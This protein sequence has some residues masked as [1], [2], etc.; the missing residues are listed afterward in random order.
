MVN[1]CYS[2]VIFGGSVYAANLPQEE[3]ALIY[4]PVPAGA[5]NSWQPAGVEVYARL[6]GRTTSYL[7]AGATTQ[8]QAALAQSDI[9]YQQLDDTV[10][11]RTYYLAAPRNNQSLDAK[12]YGRILHDDGYQILLRTTPQQAAQLAETGAEIAKLN[13]TLLQAPTAVE[14][15]PS[16]IDADPIV[17][18][19]ID[20]VSE[21]AVYQYDGSLSGEWPIIISGQEYTLQ[22]RHTYSGVPIQKATEYVGQHLA[23]L[24][25]NV[26]YH[27]WNGSTYPNV[28]AELPGQTNPEQIFIICAHLDDMPSGST[29]PGADDNASGSSGVL[30]AA[31]IL[32]QYQWDVTLRFALW[33]GEEQGLLGSNAYATLAQSNGTQIIGVLNMDMIAYNSDRNVALDLHAKSTLPDSVNLAYLF[34]DVVSEYALPLEPEVFID[35]WIGNYSDNASFWNHGFSAIL[36]IEDDDDFTPHYHTTGDQLSTLNLG[37]FTAMVRASLATFAHLGGLPWHG[38]VQGEV[39]AVTD[40]TPLANATITFDYP[41]NST[42]TIT[43][44]ANG[45]YT[46][47]LP[48][49]SYTLTVTAPNHLSETIT[50]V[51]VFHDLTTTQNIAL[52]PEEQMYF[53]YLPLT[54]N[55]TGG[56]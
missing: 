11:G 23:S 49:G 5:T 39:T 38:W 15:I 21:T 12:T 7:L 18:S 36:A 3:M 8:T 55:Q 51:Q 40:N 42:T 2:L 10:N 31:D 27:Q 32:S 22:T 28:I 56:K 37:Y 13:L 53:Y 44:D 45:I 24:G 14:V 48:T 50:G 41:V 34:D 19:M 54:W 9:S 43:A 6:N 17:Q 47:T 25:L 1:C 4:V 20:Q 52:T 16:D 29:A 30:I 26:E 46:A 35:S 33:T